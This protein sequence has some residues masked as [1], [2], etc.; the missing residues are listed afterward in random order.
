MHL[1]GSIVSFPKNFGC[2]NLD[3]LGGHIYILNG[4]GQD[5]LNLRHNGPL[6][7]LD[8]STDDGCQSLRMA[9]WG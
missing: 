2:S 9:W 5:E 3:H 4:I 8:P 6:L 1:Q 7:S